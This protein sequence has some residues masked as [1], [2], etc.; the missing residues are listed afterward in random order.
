MK[1][2]G[3][4]AW[5]GLR[6][7]GW[8]ACFLFM[9]SI[10]CPFAYGQGAL[11]RGR[12]FLEGDGWRVVQAD[13][14]M[15]ME[16][17]TALRHSVWEKALQDPKGGRGGAWDKIR[18]HRLYKGGLSPKA[19]VFIFPGTWMSGDQITQE[20][21]ML[22]VLERATGYV[23]EHPDFAP[24]LDE[25]RSDVAAFPKRSIAHFLALNGYDVYTM[26]Y[27][28]HF[29]PNTLAPNKL[30]FM[31]HW[32][33][34]MF[35]QDG[36]EAIEKAKSVSGFPKV[37]LGGQ[38]FGGMLAMNYA[39]GFWKSDVN[40]LIL[41]DGG[42]GGRWNIRIPLTL[43]DMVQF[44]GSLNSLTSQSLSNPSLI[45]Q[46]VLPEAIQGLIDTTTRPLIYRSGMFALD[47]AMDFG[48]MN[49]GTALLMNMLKAMGLPIAV[50]HVPHYPE[51]VE[52]ATQH[53]L[54]EPRDPL[55]GEYL[56]P[57]DS[58]TGKPFRTYLDWSGELVYREGLVGMFSNFPAG[59]ST[60]TTLA[61]WAATL[62]RY[63]PLEVYLESIAQFSFSL[64][65]DPE[66]ARLLGIRLDLSRT[67]GVLMGTAPEFMTYLAQTMAPGLQ[68]A[69][70]QLLGSNY[71]EMPIR[72]PRYYENYKDINV[73]LISFQ[74]RL[75]LMIWGPYNPGI[76]S[77]D[78]T[79]GGSY[80]NLG[81][82]DIFLGTRNP[83]LVNRPMLEWLDRRV[84]SR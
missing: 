12:A 65:A 8:S 1:F 82:L 21:L 63:W 49:H 45:G 71:L 28:T 81:H 55:T 5:R 15:R 78:V 67:P 70:S 62:D 48:P 40:G 76:A 42:N 2:S 43:W 44:K 58:N 32:G 23:Q 47:L 61:W 64:S 38:S 19:A 22:Q 11:G 39:S 34:E 27:R 7:F 18:L 9:A 10:A 54:E 84:G 50:Y 13:T 60:R 14:P 17:L 59:E 57:F 80:P 75:G 26:D 24:Y 36:K 31:S 79:N 51:V 46:E 56:E 66:V 77:K 74:S 16:G 4:G 33:W 20:A 30:T 35:I 69:S 29:V 68:T 52:H 41:I 72:A 73:P 6:L 25:I 37:W 3:G 53:L 83:E